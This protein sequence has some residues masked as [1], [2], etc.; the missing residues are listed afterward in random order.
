[1]EESVREKAWENPIEEAFGLKG[2]DIRTYSP[3]VL[4]FIGDS[5]YDLVIRTFIVEQGNTHANLLHQKT[6]RLV[7]AET[8]AAVADILLP[9]LK[10]DELAVYKRGRNAKA[11]TKSRNAST[12][13]YRKATG[14]EALVG[15]LYL[16]HQM[17]R[18]L[19]LIKTGLDRRKP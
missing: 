6:S 14:L 17:E 5:V 15:Y 7:K 18:I 8:Q 9:L 4:A 10:P 19:E 1:M 3:L 12:A 11:G 16:D 2:Q 13:D